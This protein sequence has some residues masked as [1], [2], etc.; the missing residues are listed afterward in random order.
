MNARGAKA[1]TP[2]CKRPPSTR[3]CVA[4]FEDESARCY[5][6]SPVLKATRPPS[7]RLFDIPSVRMS[8]D[9]EASGERPGPPK[10]VHIP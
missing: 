6:E 5:G 3:A 2:C 7:V 9:E 1:R 4:S 8:S 10:S